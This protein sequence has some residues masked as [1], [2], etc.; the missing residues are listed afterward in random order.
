M[1]PRAEA[2]DP[3]PVVCLDPEDPFA[4]EVARVVRRLLAA[5]SPR[6]LVGLE[7]I[8]LLD[9]SRLAKRD[10]I[11]HERRDGDFLLASYFRRHRGGPPTIEIYTDALR[12][13]R[14]ARYL[15]YPL[16]RDVF[17]ARVLFHEIG[18]HLYYTAAPAHGDKEKAA[19]AWGR[20]LASAVLRAR[21]PILFPLLRRI[22]RFRASRATAG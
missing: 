3:V 16:L 18:H 10:R 21:Y 2:A 8:T 14:R 19:E 1:S 12:R 7:R 13:S 6:N 5:T 17:I 20:Q 9:S 15:K 22:M 4:A 11:R